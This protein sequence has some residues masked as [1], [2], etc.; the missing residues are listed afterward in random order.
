ML[1]YALRK[2]SLSAE[3]ND[4]VAQV[5]DSR[6]YSQNEIIDLMADKGSTVTR[7]DMAAVLKLNEE[8]MCKIIA[9]GGCINTPLF[10]SIL[11]I[12]GLF[13]NPYDSFDHNRNA[14][15]IRFTPGVLLKEVL[16]KIKLE[17]VEAS[18]TEPIIT[19]ITD[20]VSGSVNSFLTRGGVVRITGNRLKF[21]A[22]D[23][24]Q[25]IFI[26]S[27]TDATIRCDAVAENKPKSVVVMIP[28]EVEE[29]NCHI[30]IR[31]RNISNG[32]PSKHLRISRF[33]K[34]LVLA[35]SQRPVMSSK[36]K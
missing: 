18:H 13:K 24:E 32:R 7:A 28:Q 22:A 9:D 8:V 6:S 10:N 15:H 14:I 34:P 33:E 3:E 26:V 27:E 23:P 29:G 20:V 19:Q 35:D 1:K 31:L 17:K 2:N 25:G 11:S 5:T 16:R 4:F 30:E 36:K 12:S 21:D